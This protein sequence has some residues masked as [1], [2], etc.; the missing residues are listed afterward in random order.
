MK[1]ILLIVA[2]TLFIASCQYKE[3]LSDK[4]VLVDETAERSEL[5]EYIYQNFEKPYNIRIDYKWKNSDFDQGKYLYPPTLEKVKPMLEIVKKVWIEPYTEIAGKNFLKLVAPRQISLVGGSN[6][7]RDGTVTLGVAEGGVRITLFNVDQLDV[8]NETATRQYFH[9]IQHEYCHIINQTLDFN[10]E[11]YLSVTPG[12]YLASWFNV[13]MAEAN[14]KG[15]IT[16]YSM[17]N[18]V[19]DFAEITAAMLNTSKE[20][21]DARVNAI[22]SESGKKAIRTKEALVAEYFKGKWNINIY[23]LQA[24]IEEKMQ[25]VLSQPQQP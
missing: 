11:E 18:E 5:D 23:E 2:T 9:T 20:K 7:N 21:F 1:K 16:P 22:E 14:A 3:K 17:A 6:V 24:K 4:S 8:R 13:R 15:F 12:E 25:E 19:E 10:K